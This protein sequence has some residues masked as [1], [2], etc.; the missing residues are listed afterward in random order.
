M[1]IIK[2][3]IIGSGPIKEYNR[4]T[5]G[6]RKL[7]KLVDE[8]GR[9][10]GAI[11]FNESIKKWETLLE[12]GQFCYIMN[13]CITPVNPNFLFANKEIEIGFIDGT[14]VQECRSPFSTVAFSNKFASFE[15]EQLQSMGKT[16]DILESL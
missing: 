2:V 8:E 15:D 1:S 16:L 5:T 6:T 12:Q 7:L 4:E 9:K 13:N 14:I 10:L 11:L 3:L